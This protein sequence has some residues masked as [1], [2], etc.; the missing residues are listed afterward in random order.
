MVDVARPVQRI[1]HVRESEALGSSLSVAGCR[2]C[3]QGQRDVQAL[4]QVDS[5]VINRQAAG[6]APVT[7]G[8]L[9][10]EQASPYAKSS[11]VLPKLVQV[12]TF[13]EHASLQRFKGGIF[14]REL[15][16]GDFLSRSD[17]P[18]LGP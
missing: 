5:G 17:E 15:E 18:L 4:T 6:G 14:A 12:A 13:L 9:G 10:L 2:R 16:R 7:S 11:N 3:Q 1:V 8:E